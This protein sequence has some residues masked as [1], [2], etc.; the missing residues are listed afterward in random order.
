MMACLNIREMQ[1]YLESHPEDRDEVTLRNTVESH[2]A[3]CGKCRSA[4]DKL[5]ATHQRVNTWLAELAFR[6][7]RGGGSLVRFAVPECAGSGAA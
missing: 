5:S 4:F 1:G 2:L 6:G 7:G 3:G